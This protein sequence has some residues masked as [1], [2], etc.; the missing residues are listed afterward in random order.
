MKLEWANSIYLLNIF[1]THY[2]T[3]HGV[4]PE[5]YH[6]SINGERLPI[7][8]EFLPVML[9]HLKF[10]VI[11]QSYTLQEYSVFQLLLSTTS[12]I[13]GVATM[14]KIIQIHK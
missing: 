9:I 8:R 3:K 10:N 13:G 6:Y 7:S 5:M 11:A 4:F 14:L 12:V 1:P 2:A